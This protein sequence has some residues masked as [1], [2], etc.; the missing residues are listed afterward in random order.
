MQRKDQWVGGAVLIAIG[1]ALL[2]GQLV[3]ETGQFVTLGIGLVLLVLF[4]VSR[5]PG[6]LIGGGIVTGIGAGVLVAA[7][8]EGDIAGAAV[9]FG[10][11]FGFIGVWLIGT[12]LR[13]KEITFWPLIPG[14]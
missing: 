8:T 6:T 14:A 5:N 2:L 1:V 12:L 7:N 10:L 9:L 13:I 11:G 4:A 3:G